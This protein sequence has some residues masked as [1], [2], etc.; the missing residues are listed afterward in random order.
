MVML[1]ELRHFDVVD[2][3]G[4]KARL[5]DLEVALLDAEYP[6]VTHLYFHLGKKLKRMEWKA[7]TAFERKQKRIGVADLSHAETTSYDD[8]G[9]C[10]LLVDDILD[11]LII[12]L[13]RRTTT[14]ATDLQLTNTDGSL[15]LTAADAGLSAMVRRVT[16]GLYRHV[17]R[18]SL[19]DWK[20]IEFLRG[21]PTEARSGAGYHM[22]I[23]RLAAGEIARLADYIPY[24]H[25]AELVILLPDEKAADVLEAMSIERQLQVF[26]ELDEK[27]AV[28][29]LSRMSPDLAADLC[30]R[31]HPQTMK[32]YLHKLPKT[33]ADRIVEL[34]QYPEDAV[35]GVMINDMI[36][37]PAGM[38]VAAAKTHLKAHLKKPDFVS[39]IYII[40][41]ADER[42]LKGVVTLRATFL[43]QKMK[44]R[45]SKK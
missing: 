25:A 5:A 13:A 28:K 11:G 12:E 30:G 41:D 10:V 32:L 9:S 23:S 15:T 17:A 4:Q 8:L 7:V 16:G 19:Y 3:A 21:D 45:H 40:D 24:L 18:R 22:R 43:L 1:S 14:R 37:C 29:L 35:G 26:E 33:D 20:Y 34:L 36:V 42:V 31:L 38:T 6:P 27:E 2:D 44:R 39:L